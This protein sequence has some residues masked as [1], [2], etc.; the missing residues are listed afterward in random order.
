MVCSK[1]LARTRQLEVP[2]PDKKQVLGTQFIRVQG[3]KFYVKERR[4]GRE[5]V[6]RYKGHNV[7]I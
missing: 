6:D 7:V 2:N 5:E 4:D 1:E 3:F